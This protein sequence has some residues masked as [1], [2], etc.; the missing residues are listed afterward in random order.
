MVFTN[1]SL[2]RAYL[3]ET[4]PFF[5]SLHFIQFNT[6]KEVNFLETYTF[7]IKTFPKLQKVCTWGNL[8]TYERV[9][10]CELLTNWGNKAPR[11]RKPHGGVRNRRPFVKRGL[12]LRCR[13]SFK[14]IA[15]IHFVYLI[16]HEREKCLSPFINCQQAKWNTCWESPRTFLCIVQ[17]EHDA[18]I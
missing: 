6:D 9:G 3:E 1:C 7:Y 8:W 15:G 17:G 11:K 2:W 12:G 5:E 16:R 4:P 10:G 14:L 13:Q 18:M